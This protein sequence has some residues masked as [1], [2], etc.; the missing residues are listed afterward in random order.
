MTEEKN[1]APNEPLVHD[2]RLTE[3]LS[4]EELEQLER[5]EDERIIALI[6]EVE[7]LDSL[8]SPEAQDLVR[9]LRPYT[10]ADDVLEE[11]E[12]HSTWRDHLADKIAQVAGSWSFIISFLLFMGLWIGT[13]FVLATQAFDPYP[14]I[15]LN[16]GL[17]TLAALQAP[18]ILMSQNRQAEK[19]R[20]VTHNDYQVNIKSELEIADLHRKMDLL[21]ATI[22]T[23]GQLIQLLAKNQVP[24]LNG[25]ATK[26]KAQG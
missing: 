13:N 22:D 3:L 7:E 23:Q 12:E 1:F 18:V 20:A 21:M 4:E 24:H 11:L 15:L 6:D 2:A 8:L 5:E 26:Q 25:A 9:D 16:L 17:S 10:V 14:F 19:D